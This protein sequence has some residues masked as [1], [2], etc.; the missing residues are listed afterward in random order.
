[1]FVSRL[2]DVLRT[3]VPAPALLLLAAFRRFH[4]KGRTYREITCGFRAYT[5]GTISN[6][7]KNNKIS[8]CYGTWISKIYSTAMEGAK[9]DYDNWDGGRKRGTLKKLGKRGGAGRGW[10]K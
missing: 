2:V 8:F 4:N 1:M 7:D 10:G 9:R 5:V 3:L 6:G